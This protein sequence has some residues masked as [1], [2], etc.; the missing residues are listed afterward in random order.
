MLLLIFATI[1]IYQKFR[2]LA[3]VKDLNKTKWGLIGCF[4]YLG[5]GL[6]FPFIIGIMIGLNLFYLNLEDFGTSFVLS[7]VSYGL[8]GLCAYLIYQ[9]LLSF[10]DKTPDIENFGKQEQDTDR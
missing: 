10:P 9:K 8:G 5:I 4:V 2:D 7:L 3:I 1:Y 6:G